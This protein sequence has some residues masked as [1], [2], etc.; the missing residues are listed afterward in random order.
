MAKLHSQV[1]F[2]RTVPWRWREEELA[3]PSVLVA[4][5]RLLS[6]R[7]C[8]GGIPRTGPSRLSATGRGRVAPGFAAS[9]KRSVRDATG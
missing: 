3:R 2:T 7:N 6:L 8:R 5:L 1:P 4:D 9:W